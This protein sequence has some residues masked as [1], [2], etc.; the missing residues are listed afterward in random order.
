MP[1][2]QAIHLVES[3]L[4]G[5][6]VKDFSCSLAGDWI[7]T[8]QP[9]SVVEELLDTNYYIFQHEED[10]ELMIRTLEWSIPVHLN[11]HIDAIQPTNSFWR[12]KAQDKFGG[13]PPPLWE[14]EGRTPTHEELE[15]ED[16]LERGHL[17]IPNITDLPS[18]PTVDQACNRLA[19]SPLCLRTLYGTLDYVS[20]APDKNKIALVNFNGNVNNRSD[21]S[22]YLENYRPDAAATNTAYTFKTEIVAGGDDQQ[23]PVTPEQLLHYKGFEGALD[24]ETVLGVGYPTP[25]ITYNVGGKPPFLA[26]NLTPNNTNEPYLTW[27]QYVLAQPVLPQVIT[28]SYADEEQAVPYSYARRVCEGF[29]QLGARGVSVIVAS[30]DDG[31]GKDGHCFSNDGTKKPQWLPTFPASCPFVTSV[32]ATRLLNPEIAGFDRR[33]N[34]ISGGGFSNYFSRP[35]YQDQAVGEYVHNLGDDFTGDGFYNKMGRGVPDVAAQGYH[36]VIMW[37]GVA[38]LRDGTSASS[39]TVASVIALVNDALIA[40]GK[41]P[42]GFLNPWLYSKGFKAFT[43][44]TIGSSTGCN[45]TGFPAKK[46]WDAVTGFGTPVSIFLI[47][48]RAIGI[49]DTCLQ[50]GFLS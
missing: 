18:H 24:A 16:L 50:S 37:N 45:T 27:L 21:I 15:E 4:V 11:D 29:A 17:D 33:G 39:P 20:Q 3:W 35:K 26:S 8:S 9:I 13:I 12:P 34:F 43:D 1:S 48:L 28:I 25:L 7:T 49:A 5:R 22:L 30:G 19:I 42:L 40:D 41:P 6:G 10:Q 14:V 2:E 47:W 23:T 32:G 44:I 31:V 38:H 36:Y 46:G